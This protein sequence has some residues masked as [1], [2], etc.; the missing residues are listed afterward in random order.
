M[1]RY[2]FNF[3]WIYSWQSGR[4]PERPDLKALDFLA[5]LGFDSAR[6]PADYR[7]WTKGG[8]YRSQDESVLEAIDSYV[9]ACGERGIQACLNLHRAPGYCIN[10]PELETHNLWLDEEAQEGFAFIWESFARRYKG[11]PND[12]LSFDLLNEPPDEGARGMSRERHA[13]V[14]RRA[15][16]AI[17]SADPDR[18]I[19]IDGVGGGGLAI[20][21]LADLGAI[22]SGRGYAPMPLSHYGASWWAPSAGLS[23]PDY[24]GLEWNGQAWDQET[25]RG[26]YAPWRA[27]EEKGVKVHIGECGCYKRTPNDV[28]MRWFG[29]LFGLFKEYGWGFSLWNF[30]GDFGIVEHGRPGARYERYRGYNVDR[31]L[32]DLILECRAS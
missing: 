22:H 12:R 4:K 6:I 9:E 11:V 10:R 30:V 31:A 8:D 32:L 13:A 25:L 3:Q 14:I 24:P 17:R 19:V 29:D 18:E 28:A 15:A 16:A 2:G 7:F 23:E 27:V 1:P 26:Y 20:P 21:E 5:D